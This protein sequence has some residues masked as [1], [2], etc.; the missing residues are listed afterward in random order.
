MWC[1]ET[2]LNLSKIPKHEQN[3]SFINL[4]HKTRLPAGVNDCR[5]EYTFVI[6]K[7]NTKA[8]VEL[9]SNRHFNNQMETF[10]VNFSS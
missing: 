5:K 4:V 2:V 9:F 10:A 3:F 8:E 1:I 6:T 7:L